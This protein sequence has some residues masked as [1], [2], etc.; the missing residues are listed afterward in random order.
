MK[1]PSNH[2]LFD[3]M[4]G[5]GRQPGNVVQVGANSGQEIPAFVRYGV[6]WAI[7]IEPLDGPYLELVSASAK[8]PRYVPIQALCSS[9]AGQ[10]ATF[11]VASNNGQSSS[12]LRP[13]RH[14]TEIPNVKFGATLEMQ[15]TTVDRV[16]ADVVRDHP[17]FGGNSFNSLLIDVQGAELKVLMGSAELLQHVDHV[18]AEVSGDLYEGGATLDDLQGFL[19][20]FG[21]SLNNVR[22]DRLNSGDAL[23]VRR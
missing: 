19:R 6:A 16:V 8:H 2:K 4:S 5:L 15:T 20:P 10:T 18:I 23:F 13:L 14:V 9:E 22:L 3:W 7:M 21:F 11:W 1:D 12:F 17:A